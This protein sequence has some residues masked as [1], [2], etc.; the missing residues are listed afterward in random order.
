MADQLRNQLKERSGMFQFSDLTE[1]EMNPETTEGTNGPQP[2]EEP[3]RRDSEA[4]IPCIELENPNTEQ[5]PT[6]APVSQ[7]PSI[8][9]RAA[10]SEEPR[11]S[12]L[13]GTEDP[14]GEE[15]NVES[16]GDSSQLRG[17]S[18]QCEHCRS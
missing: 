13:R 3:H 18:I 5:E 10:E 16:R 7:T 4:D 11:G 6:S 15:G 9:E 12:D 2:E 8:A 14:N 17:R 1:L